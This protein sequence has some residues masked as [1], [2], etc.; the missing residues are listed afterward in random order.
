MACGMGLVLLIRELS[1]KA[2]GCVR[3][4]SQTVA[5]TDQTVIT[6]LLLHT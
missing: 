6:T 4:L 5:Y 2:A 1:G 3:T